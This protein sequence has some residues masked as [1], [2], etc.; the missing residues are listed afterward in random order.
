[1]PTSSRRSPLPRWLKPAIGG[2]LVGVIGARI[3][4]VL[5]TGYGWVQQGLGPGLLTIPL[6]IVLVL[7]FA[8]I[9]ATGAVHRLRRLGRHLRAGHGHRRVP[10]R[11]GLAAVRTG[12][13]AVPHSPAP[14]VIVGMMCCFGSIAQAPLAVM[15]M[16]AR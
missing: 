16:V 10:R 5:G 9:L 3:P 8:K 6:W 1:M 15:L 7:P 14:Y 12:S 11:R 4:E 13:P 2:L